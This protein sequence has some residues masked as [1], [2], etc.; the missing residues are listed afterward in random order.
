MKRNL[1]IALF[2]TLSVSAFAQPA[3][4]IPEN[5]YFNVAERLLHTDGSLKIGGYGGVHYNQ[6]LNSDIRQNGLMDVHRF[7]MLLVYS[8]SN[9]THFISEIEFEHVK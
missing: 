1:L 9:K 2:L 6:P 7:I 5:R 8:F 4:S 3:D